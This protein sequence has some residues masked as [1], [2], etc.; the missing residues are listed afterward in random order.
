MLD[1]IGTLAL[2]ITMV[3]MGYRFASVSPWGGMAGTL[4]I[5]HVV[6]ARAILVPSTPGRTAAITAL[7]FTAQAVAQALL[8]NSHAIAPD[9]A[10]TWVRLPGKARTF[11][12]TFTYRFD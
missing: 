11:G 1:G 12:A 9:L 2:C 6:L 5:F 8:P 3:V 10:N 4:S 7:S